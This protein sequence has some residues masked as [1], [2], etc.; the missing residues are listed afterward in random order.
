MVLKDDEVSL[1][2]AS[3]QDSTVM[4]GDSELLFDSL[5]NVHAES[6]IVGS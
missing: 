1:F 2:N 4:D 3:D 6:D 5:V